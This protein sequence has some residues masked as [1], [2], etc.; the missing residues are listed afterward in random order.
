VAGPLTSQ[1]RKSWKD[2]TQ[3]R[4]RRTFVSAFTSAAAGTEC[5]HVIEATLRAHGCWKVGHLVP[6]ND[7]SVLQ[8]EADAPA[9]ML[10]Y[11]IPAEYRDSD[12]ITVVC[13]FSQEFALC[14]E[15]PKQVGVSDAV[16][17]PC[18]SMCV[19]GGWCR[20]GGAS[21][22]GTKPKVFALV[23]RSSDR[24]LEPGTY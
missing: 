5:A 9:Q 3:P 16:P 18:G 13:A 21:A 12:A 8:N 22:S 15:R 4:G 23:R 2:T 17:V 14:I 10:H 7:M 11:D 24:R 6:A 19:L 20:H 1:V